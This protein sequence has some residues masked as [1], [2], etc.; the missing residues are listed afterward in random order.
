[1]VVALLF[2]VDGLLA[3]LVGVQAHLDS[4]A[5]H[6]LLNQRLTHLGGHFDVRPTLHR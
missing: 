3:A 6:T 4:Y 1:M 5:C 2:S